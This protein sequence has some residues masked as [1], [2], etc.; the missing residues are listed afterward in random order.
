MSLLVP[1]RFHV[2]CPTEIKGFQSL[3]SDFR[4]GGVAVIGVAPIRSSRHGS[5]IARPSDE[6]THP[7]LADTTTR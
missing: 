4:D 6:I 3:A 7:V 1:A 5:P 2:V